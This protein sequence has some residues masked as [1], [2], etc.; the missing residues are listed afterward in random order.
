MSNVSISDAVKY[1]GVDDHELD[2][3]EGQYIIPN[4]IAYNSYVILDEKTAI[5]DTVDARFADQWLANLETQL[6]GKAPH[7]LIIS[8]MEPDHSSVIGRIFDLYPDIIGVCSARALPMMK[9]FFT[10]DY[11]SR[12]MVVNEGDT[13]ALGAHTLKFL[14]APMVHWPEVMVTYEQEEKILFSADA[15]GKFGALDADEAWTCEA[16]RYYFNICGKYGAQVPALLKKVAQHD[17]RTICPLHGPILSENL[18]YYIDK[19]NTWSSY[20][21]EDK[22]I[23]IAYCSL[24]GNTAQAA[25]ALADILAAKSDIKV[26]TADIA[27]DDM[28]EALEDAFRH[29][30]LVLAAPTYDGGIMPVMDTFLHHLASKNFQNRTV[31][32]IENGSWAPMAGRKMCEM[33]QTFKNIRIL[34]P[35]I[36]V[37]STV[38]ESTLEQLNALADQLLQ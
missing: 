38:K 15:F 17:I 8:H 33:L 9:R 37:E 31:G 1:I 4:G 34:Q 3:F 24:H 32:I 22:G 13:I 29:D 21:A 36:T 2:L 12:M 27:R 14:M 23:F 16:R 20:E 26:A 5:L 10:T 7:Y 25:Q 18:E 35:I 11:S 6:Q 19:Y 30:R 28:A